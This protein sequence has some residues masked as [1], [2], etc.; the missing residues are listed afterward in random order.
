[1]SVHYVHFL[2][3]FFQI[4][5]FSIGEKIVCIGGFFVFLNLFI[6][7]VDLIDYI[8]NIFLSG[9][10]ADFKVYLLSQNVYRK[11]HQVSSFLDHGWVIS[12]TEKREK[13]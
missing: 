7:F 12:D 3:R 4:R 6:Q 10:H 1:M 2:D 13:R 9:Y 8:F 11:I 5:L